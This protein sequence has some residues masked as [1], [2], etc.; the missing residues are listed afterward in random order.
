M[1]VLICV[2][3][4]YPHEGGFSVNVR[5]LARR[6]T[7]RGY[8]IIIL[9]C[10]T[11]N[12][13]DYEVSEGVSVYRLPCWHLLGGTY[14]IPKPS[15]LLWKV[16]RGHYDMV[17]TQTR[18]FIVSLLGLIIA[19][20]KRIP[21][22]H[23]E[24]GTRHTALQNRVI[25]MVSRIYDHTIGTLIMKSAKVNT[26]VSLAACRFAEH[27]G[28]RQ[29]VVVYNGVDADGI[30][31][32][33]KDSE[34]KV[35]AYV[36]RLIWA[37]GVQDLISAFAIIAKERS[38]V[39][40]WVIGEGNYR[41]DLESLAHN[42]SLDGSK[43]AFM[44]DCPH[45]RI[46]GILAGAD[47]FVNPSYSEGLPTSVMEAMAVGLPVVATD[48]GGTRELIQDGYN[49]YLVTPGVPDILAEAIIKALDCSAEV[50]ANAR[51]TIQDSF[52]WD[53]SISKMV[54]VYKKAVE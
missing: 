21:L 42:M 19:R 8:S 53:S 3:Y 10:N 35:I 31:L 23:T 54:E 34:Y 17:H 12:M 32:Q 47:M 5:E 48:V 26:G 20:V 11:D 36:G 39:E 29:T 52:S 49:G 9:T 18:F 2:A 38:A 1:H 6:L 27:L 4:Y 28:A 14:P 37:K 15:K 41:D 30:S 40:L 50:G 25:D 22:V 45:E 13:P 43:V 16:I 51:R 7:S 46:A 44:G 33:R 24:R